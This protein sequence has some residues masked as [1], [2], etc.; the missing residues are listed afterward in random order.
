MSVFG[1]L[2]EAV[3]KLNPSE[4]RAQAEQPLVIRLRAGSEAAYDSLFRL[5]L[6]DSLS[7]ERRRRSS[8]SIYLDG[9]PNRP[10]HIDISIVERGEMASPND[11][12][13]TPGRESM[14]INEILNQRPHLD[15]ALARTFP[16]FR[17]E[18]TRRTIHK[19]SGENAMF[20]IATAIPNIAPY[21]G[22]VWSPAEFAS[23]TAFLTLNQIRMIF[24]LG[25]ASDRV[26][27][28]S[29]QKSEVAS[30]ITGAFGWRAVAR[31]LAGK[32]PA[33]GGII[34][35]AAI[36]YAGTWVV[37][38]SIERLYRIG[39]GYTRAE[40]KQAYSE[41]FDRGK[42]VASAVVKKFRKAG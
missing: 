20:S 6:P 25:A 36:A 30:I 15:L 16:A 29:E 18:V 24:M 12:V 41:A 27:G 42:E 31:E 1:Q 40:R 37:G 32:I 10:S 34:P 33:G 38:A 3:G 9:E 26:A 11:F 5:L 39:Y 23:D 19:V 7:A 8:S 35:K 2:R 22:L 4:V 17:E 13:Y 14:L 28:Y 21:L